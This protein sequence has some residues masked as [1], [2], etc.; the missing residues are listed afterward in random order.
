MGVSVPA[1]KNQIDRNGGE[2][3]EARMAKDVKVVKN[4]KMSVTSFWDIHA[5]GHLST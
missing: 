1:R 4:I 3:A 5:N 2:I